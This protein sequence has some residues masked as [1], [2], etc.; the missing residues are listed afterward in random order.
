[1]SPSATPTTVQSSS[2]GPSGIPRRYTAVRGSSEAKIH[3]SGTSLSECIGLLHHR[4][5]ARQGG[6]VAS[7]GPLV[8][9]PMSGH[10]E[11]GT[12]MVALTAIGTPTEIGWMNLEWSCWEPIENMRTAAPALY[13]VQRRGANNVFYIGQT[14]DLGARSRA[15]ARTLGSEL[16]SLTPSSKTTLALPRCLTLRMTFWAVLPASWS[17]TVL[18]VLK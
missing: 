15:H 13:R 3:P 8:V 16:T 6:A 2:A 18:A 1:V 12:R 9:A 14:R 10:L 7:C 11:R 17:S 4:L 5:R